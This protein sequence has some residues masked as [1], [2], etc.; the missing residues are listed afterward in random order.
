MD[1]VA[2][3]QVAAKELQLKAAVPARNTVKQLVERWLKGYL[4]VNVLEVNVKRNTYI[5][6][7]NRTYKW[8][9]NRWGNLAADSITPPSM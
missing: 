8:I 6:V 7:Q 2:D 4:E 5:S 3:R 9:V 1:I